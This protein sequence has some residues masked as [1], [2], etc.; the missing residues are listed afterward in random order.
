MRLSLPRETN[1]SVLDADSSILSDNG[2][3]G[4]AS[5]FFSRRAAVRV[6]CPS[7]RRST[8]RVRRIFRVGSKTSFFP[9]PF[10]SLRVVL[11]SFLFPGDPV[12]EANVGGAEAATATDEASDPFWNI[13]CCAGELIDMAAIDSVRNAWE[14]LERH[15]RSVSNFI[16]F[17]LCS[18]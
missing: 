1:R 3:V 16:E 14:G 10:F 6:R 5:L 7:F 13:D 12:L 9:C 2:S 8:T 11:F 18:Q 15:R 4:V 17:R